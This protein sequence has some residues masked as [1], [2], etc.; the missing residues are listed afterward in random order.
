MENLTNYIDACSESKPYTITVQMTVY[1][2]D[3]EHAKDEA[4]DLLPKL[5]DGTDFNGINVVEAV[6]DITFI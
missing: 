6:E 5:L 4:Q 2:N 3:K 1:T